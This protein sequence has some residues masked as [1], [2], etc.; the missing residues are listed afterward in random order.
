MIVALLWVYVVQVF[1]PSLGASRAHHPVVVPAA[2][3]SGSLAVRKPPRGDPCAGPRGNASYVEA[4]LAGAVRREAYVMAYG[5]CFYLLGGRWVGGL[6]VA[7]VP[8]NQTVI[9]PGSGGG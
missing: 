3:R 9:G 7:F 2:M 8:A 1:E 4:R 5:D 6:K